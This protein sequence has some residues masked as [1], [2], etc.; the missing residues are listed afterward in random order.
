MVPVVRPVVAG[1]VPAL[2]AMLVRSFADDP[3]ANFMFAGDR[4]LFWQGPSI[5]VTS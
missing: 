3:V 1:D 4:R 2:A 5:G